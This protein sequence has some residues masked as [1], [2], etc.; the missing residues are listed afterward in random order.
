M[1]NKLL[2][3]QT[4]HLIQT[5]GQ[6]DIEEVVRDVLKSLM[7][8]TLK[9][10]IIELGVRGKNEFPQHW[11]DIYTVSCEVVALTLNGQTNVC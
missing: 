10:T 11:S 2:S 4:S 6:R 1:L 8:D 7:T 9:L 5:H 3:L